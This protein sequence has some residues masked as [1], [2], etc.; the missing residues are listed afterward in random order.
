[1]SGCFQDDLT[2]DLRGLEEMFI[3]G[4]EK[5][6]DDAE[7]AEIYEISQ[8]IKA[9][10]VEKYEGMHVDPER[11]LTWLKRRRHR[12]RATAQEKVDKQIR[13]WDNFFR[14]HEKYFYAG[15]VIHPSLEGEPIR[16]LC[17]SQ[18]KPSKST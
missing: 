8:D 13:H 12:R 17:T 7:A 9:G 15:K 10:D 18:G 6:E 2:W 14:N 16:K 3:T 11:R 4:E 5:K 1:M